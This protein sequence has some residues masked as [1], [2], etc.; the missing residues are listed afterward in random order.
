MARIAKCILHIAKIMKAQGQLRN[1]IGV[2]LLFGWQADVEADAGRGGIAAPRLAASMMPGPPRV[3]MTLSRSPPS[4]ARAPS[5]SETRRPSR[6]PSRT[7]A[8]AGHRAEPAAK[9]ASPYRAQQVSASFG[10]RDL[11]ASEENDGAISTLD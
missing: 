2:R 6:A 1:R 8:F 11:C 7:I 3:A 5:L 10:R 4:A 9:S